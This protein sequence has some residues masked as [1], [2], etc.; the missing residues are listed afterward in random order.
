MAR[1]DLSDEE[2]AVIEPLLPQ[3]SRGARRGDDRKVKRGD[4]MLLI[5]ALAPTVSLRS[6]SPLTKRSV[7]R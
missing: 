1:F 2:W 3:Q 7:G 6:P 5:Q 4:H